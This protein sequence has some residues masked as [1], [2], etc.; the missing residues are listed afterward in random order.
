MDEIIILLILLVLSGFF[1]GSETA[2]T[3]LSM[4]RV[5]ALLKEGRTGAQALHRLKSNTNRMLISIL[6]GN[7][8]VNIAASA[9]ATVLATQAFGDLG[10]GLAVGVRFIRR[11]YP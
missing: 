4:V 2:L 5:E 9:M 10:P 8:L 1:S 11:R 7:N 6:I 3:S